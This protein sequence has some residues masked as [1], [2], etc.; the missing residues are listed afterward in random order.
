MATGQQPRSSVRL[1]EGHSL[2]PDHPRPGREATTAT[3]G[4][5]MGCYRGQPTREISR[6]YRVELFNIAGLV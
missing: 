5:A 3:T 1:A 6:A 4:P 2:L